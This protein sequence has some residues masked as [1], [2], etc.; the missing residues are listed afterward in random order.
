MSRQALG[1]GLRSL[2]PQS[3]TL[4]RN[5]VSQ[6]EV[7]KITANPFQPRKHFDQEK[8]EELAESIKNHG[9]LEPIIVRRAGGEYQI[10]IGERRWRA[11]QLAGLATVPAVVK[12]LSDR[13]MTEMA[14]I[15]NLQRE[16]LN[17]IE[18]AEGYQ[19]LIDEFSLTQE[20]VARSVGRKRSSVANALRLLSLEPQI[21]QMVAE[22]RLSRGHAKV[23]LSVNPG[24]QRMSLA[25][26]VV[27]ED[28]SVRQL[29]KLIQQ[30]PKPG[31]DKACRDPEVQM[32]Q[33]ELQ[34]LLGTKVRVTYKRGKG[35]IEIEYYSD[36]ELERIIELLRG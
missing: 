26:K 32:V 4:N 10:V 36:D 19:I 22:G 21:K 14:L 11:C 15:E 1:K 33:D 35:K 25:Q 34:R 9:V 6:I 27:E 13:E 17:A 23:L 29:E 16:D 30:K 18:E 24:K 8:L 3:D 2:I 5:L 20:E 28:L 7:D 31:K 12:E